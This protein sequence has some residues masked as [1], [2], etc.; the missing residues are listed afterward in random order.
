MVVNNEDREKDLDKGGASLET[1][2]V[3]EVASHEHHGEV[4]NSIALGHDLEGSHECG[5]QDDGRD[6]ISPMLRKSS[7]MKAVDSVKEATS[8]LLPAR[9]KKRGTKLNP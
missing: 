5:V 6:P 3:V 1:T 8:K 2:E 7:R 4:E 9:R